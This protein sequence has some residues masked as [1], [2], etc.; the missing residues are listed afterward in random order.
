MRISSLGET[1]GR[2]LEENSPPPPGRDQQHHS[3]LVAVSGKDA[4]I[5]LHLDL[6]FSSHLI[7][8]APFVPMRL[9]IPLL[10]TLPALA[11]GMALGD[12]FSVTPG[13]SIQDA[14]DNAADGD[15]I[16]IFGGSYSEE[17]TI[18][19][20]V[21]LTEAV[22][23]DVIISGNVTLPRSGDSTSGPG[24]P[25]SPSRTRPGWPSAA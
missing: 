22:G 7:D 17:L 1:T 10:L 5:I 6:G 14:I 8:L 23:E 19:K 18:N 24:P 15:L 11:C 20:A 12:T 2:P 16:V 13:Q 9:R 25:P 3:P 4:V 21:Q